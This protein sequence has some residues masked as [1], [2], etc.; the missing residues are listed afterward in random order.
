ME[1]S[2]LLSALRVAE[3]ACLSAEKEAAWAGDAL[4][5]SDEEAQEAGVIRHL[6][7]SARVELQ[8]AI[9]KVEDL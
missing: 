7:R 9:E 6:T 1:T 3:Q 5:E 8:V 4:T 2:D